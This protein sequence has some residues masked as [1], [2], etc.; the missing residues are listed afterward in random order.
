MPL[1]MLS[2]MYFLEGFLGQQFPPEINHPEIYYGFVGVTLAW[3]IG[4]LLIGLD[5]IRYRP[6]MLLGAFG[7]GSFVVSMALLVVQGRT[8]LSLALLV[9]PDALFVV[10][11]LVAFRLTGRT[12][13]PS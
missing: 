13:M 10:L 8:P 3:Q 4:Y 5:P 7:K 9:M 11:F 12:S 2:P 1:V 6:F